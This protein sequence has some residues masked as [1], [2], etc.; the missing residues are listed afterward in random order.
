MIYIGA[1]HAGFKLKEQIKRYFKSKDMSFE[2]LGNLKYEKTDDYP[3]YA[4][5]VAKKV[6]QTNSRGILVCGSGVGVCIAAN[7]VKGVRATQ[8]VN[9]SMA[10]QSRE[11]DDTNV[12]CFGQNFIKIKDVKKIIDVWLKTKQSP[13]KRHKRRLNK[14]KKIEK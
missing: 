1:D 8:P 14:I 13:A 5:K 10:K 7:K 6:S 3:D 9:V 4:F 12:L 2:D 11:H